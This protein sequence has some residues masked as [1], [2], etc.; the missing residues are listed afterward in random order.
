MAELL[1]EIG[2]RHHVEE[3][4]PRSVTP[5]AEVAFPDRIY[6]APLPLRHMPWVI[7]G[8]AVKGVHA[9]EKH[10]HSSTSCGVPNGRCLLFAAGDPIG[11]GT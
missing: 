4:A 11:L 6:I 8:P 1:H 7:E 2:V 10:R 3:A 5:H 9:A